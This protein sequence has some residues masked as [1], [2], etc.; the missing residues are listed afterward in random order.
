MKCFQGFCLDTTNHC[1][2]RGQERVPIAPKAYDVLRFLVENPGQL[3]T[4]DEVLEKLWPHTYVTPEVLRKC[5]SG[6]PKNPRGPAR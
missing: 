1:L 3:V 6:H 2:W 5:I 4:P